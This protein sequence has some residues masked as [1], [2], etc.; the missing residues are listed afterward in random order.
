MRTIRALDPVDVRALLIILEEVQ[1]HNQGMSTD[2]TEMERPYRLGIIGDTETSIE[3]T[4]LPPHLA[5][6][7]ATEDEIG[8]E[9]GTTGEGGVGQDL[10]A[11]TEAHPPGETWMMT[12]H[13]RFDRRMKFRMFRCWLSTKVWLG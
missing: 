9:I 5:A 2:I 12:C 7:V 3:A 10:R 4:A 1:A 8:A 11:D 13:S 6:V